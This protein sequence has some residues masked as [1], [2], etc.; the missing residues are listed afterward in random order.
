MPFRANAGYREFSR[1]VFCVLLILPAAGQNLGSLKT[2]TVPA[3]PNIQQYVRD[4]KTLVVLGKALFW[5]MQA[6]SDN[7]TACGTCHFHAGSDHRSRNQLSNPNGPFEANHQLAPDDYPFRV[8]ADGND[9]QSAVI[10][11]S[12][13]RTGSAGIFSR[14][15]AG[16]TDSGGEAGIDTFDEPDFRAGNLNLRQVTTRN[17]PSVINAVFNVRNFRDGRASDIFNGRNSF[18]DSDPRPNVLAVVNGALTPQLVRIPNSSLASQCVSPPV[19]TVEM[20]YQGRTWL[21]LGRKLLAARPLVQQHVAPDDSVLGDYANPNGPGLESSETYLSLIE[22]AFR[23]AYWD[24]G[25]LVD[26]NGNTP[27]G[28]TVAEYNFPLFFGLAIE[29][30]ESTLIADGSRFDQFAAGKS[31]ALTAEEQAGFLVFQTEAFCQFCHTGP[32]TTMAGLTMIAADGPI[33]T[34]LA[35]KAPS[36]TNLFSD[37]GFFHTGVRPADEDPGLDAT[38][39]FGV[40][41]SLADRA[42]AGPLGIAGAFKIPGLR[43]VEFTGPYFHNG[44][45]ATLEQ[46]VDFYARGGDFPDA[47]DLPVEINPVPL[48]PA[49]RAELVAFLK[50]LSDDRVRFERAPFDHPEICV[51]SG[52]PDAPAPDSAYPASAADRWAGIPAIGRSGNAIPLQTFEELL[53]GVG[54]DGT[55]AHTL[56]DACTAEWR[57]ESPAQAGGRHH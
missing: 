19:N 32:E 56:T 11:D 4:P 29:A 13:Q 8:F 5:D 14:V 10:R 34:V 1:C 36:L 15:F 3:I 39:D 43:N 53:R 27:G 38:D 9:N 37:T 45:Q 57:A 49:E 28:Y 25:Q 47:P 42:A 21:D 40:S 51:P 7:R 50:S 20:S 46:V 2:V 17:A 54:T 22:A 6:G 44:G 55:R 35:G 52:Y 16:L 41:Y 18:G 30:Y 12:A 31:D 23:P 24:S 33:A 48:G 26:A